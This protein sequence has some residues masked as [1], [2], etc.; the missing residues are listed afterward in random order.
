[1]TIKVTSLIGTML[2]TSFMVSACSQSQVQKEPAASVEP[3]PSGVEHTHP[4]NKCTNSISHSHGN[5]E[6]A[7]QHRY[8]CSPKNNTYKPKPAVEHTH[9]AQKCTRHI[10]IQQID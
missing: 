10:R 6:N 4:A 5:G 1:M 9:P 3:I 8:D 2:I 7:H